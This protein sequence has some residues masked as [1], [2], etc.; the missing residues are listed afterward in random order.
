MNK[1]FIYLILLIFLISFVSSVSFGVSPTKLVFNE[2][3]NEEICKNFSV[4]MDEGRTFNGEIKW[5][6]K[7]S[8]EISDYTLSSQDVG[9]KILFPMQIKKGQYRICISAEN[10]GE[11]YGILSYKL[12]NSS[13]A[14]GIWIEV[15]VTK[16][17]FN[18]IFLLTGKTVEGNSAEN[19]FIFTPLLLLIILIILLL[20]LKRKNRELV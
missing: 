20:N 18:P 19:F 16:N 1:I 2:K 15:N 9:L 6:N 10:E 14:V 5:S 3:Q 11:K 8:R 13:Y 12:E 4:F 17:S 7:K